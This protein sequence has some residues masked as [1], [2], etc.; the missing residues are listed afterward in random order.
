MSGD[1]SANHKLNKV[2]L[3]NLVFM[4]TI[5]QIASMMNVSENTVM[6][7]YLYYMGRSTGM[8]KKHHMMAV[9]IAPEDQPAMW[10]VSLEEF[11]KWLK[12][13]GFRQIDLTRL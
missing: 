4:F 7:T 9:N 2:G 13:M 10:R 11:R 3:P 6:G 1:T 5:D 8:Q 12:K